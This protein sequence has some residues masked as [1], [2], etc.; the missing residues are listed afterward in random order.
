M[1]NNPSENIVLSRTPNNMLAVKFPN[2]AAREAFLESIGGQQTFSAD[3]RFNAGKPCPASVDETNNVMYFNGYVAGTGS[4]VGSLGISF[5]NE[6]MRNNF[7]YTLFNITEINENK[8]YAK[9]YQGS[10]ALYIAALT[11]NNPNNAL[12]QINISQTPLK[13][14]LNNDLTIKPHEQ[15][16]ISSQDAQKYLDYMN[17]LESELS[18][19]SIRYTSNKQMG[20]IINLK[21]ILSAI[22]NGEEN[23]KEEI[24]GMGRFAG[25]DLSSNAKE[26]LLQAMN[27]QNY[28]QLPDKAK[29]ILNSVRNDIIH[30]ERIEDP[31]FVA[32]KNA[33]KTIKPLIAYL[34]TLY[35]NPMA[36]ISL[37]YAKNKENQHLPLG[38]TMDALGFKITSNRHDGLAFQLMNHEFYIDVNNLNNVDVKLNFSPGQE[39]FNKIEP[40]KID[41]L[42]KQ[43]KD[44]QAYMNKIDNQI[45]DQKPLSQEQKKVVS[46][47]TNAHQTKNLLKEAHL[48]HHQNQ[49]EVLTQFDGAQKSVEQKEVAKLGQKIQSLNNPSHTTETIAVAIDKLEKDIDSSAKKH[50]SSKTKKSSPTFQKSGFQEFLKTLKEGLQTLK[51][52]LGL[53]SKKQLSSQNSED[54]KKIQKK[55]HGRL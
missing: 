13:L 29:E 11:S 23:F 12:I 40:E 18:P 46:D 16:V 52:N 38:A 8:K 25:T 6:T 14:P 47:F 10:A 7:Y 31:R 34:S 51:T 26:A 17:N 43:I 1:A 3:S 45:P 9:A 27:E 37:Q 49:P 39:Q 4:D 42:V 48:Y 19:L 5:A 35:E 33:L 24:G 36:L 28:G 53:T 20:L 50:I 30:K 44:Y 2:K 41:A 22:A 54:N 55:R 15:V 21:N 32:E